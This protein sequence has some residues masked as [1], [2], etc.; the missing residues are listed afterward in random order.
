MAKTLVIPGP[1]PPPD[2]CT[3]IETAGTYQITTAFTGCP[4]CWN[5]GGAL[6]DGKWSNDGNNDCTWHPNVAAGLAMDNGRH[7]N[8]IGLWSMLWLDVITPAWRVLVSCLLGPVGIETW[9]GQKLVGEDPEGI[10]TR[11]SGCDLT[12]TRFITRLS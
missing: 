11:V 4:V 6:W 12:A 3:A 7:V 5:L 2:A 8:F 9:Q 1:P 10:F